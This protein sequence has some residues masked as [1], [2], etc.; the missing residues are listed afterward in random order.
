MENAKWA[1]SLS[2]ELDVLKPELAALRDERATLSAQL[3]ETQSQARALRQQM[4]DR[5]ARQRL[6]DNEI[7]RAEAQL[8]LIRD[9]LIREKNF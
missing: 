2:G 5:D 7:L 1:R 6:M 9:V 4:D 3:A 8:D